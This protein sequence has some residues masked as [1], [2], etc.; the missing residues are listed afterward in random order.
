VLDVVDRLLVDTIHTA[1]LAV[2]LVAIVMAVAV[3]VKTRS[4]GPTIAAVFFGAFVWFGATQ[5]GRMAGL[6]DT[7]VDSAEEEGPAPGLPQ[8]E[9]LGG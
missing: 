8:N 7:Q 2:L 3:W 1:R 6:I 5:I 9:E 4:F